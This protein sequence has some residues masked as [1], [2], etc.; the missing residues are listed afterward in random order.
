MDSKK[1]IVDSSVWIAYLDEDDSQH[2]KAEKVLG[3]QITPLL[4]PEY[5]LLEVVTVLRQKK[6]ESILQQFL[7]NA[8]RTGVYLPAGNIGIEVASYYTDKKYKKLSFVDVGLLMLSKQYRII[9]FDKAL[10][11][12]IETQNGL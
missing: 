3:G 6:R 5:V 10:K 12:A 11:Q 8:T 4:V 1:V 2:D 9:T 7:N